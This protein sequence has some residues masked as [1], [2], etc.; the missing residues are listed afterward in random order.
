[1]IAEGGTTP[2]FSQHATGSSIH[3]SSSISRDHSAHDHQ[4]KSRVLLSG[5]ASIASGWKNCQNPTKK[6]FF[7]P[8]GRKL[9]S[10][11]FATA[12]QLQ[13]QN[14]W[15]TKTQEDCC[16]MWLLLRLH[17]LN[18][19][20]VL[21]VRRESIPRYAF[22]FPGIQEWATLFQGILGQPGIMKCMARCQ[23]SQKAQQATRAAHRSLRIDSLQASAG[24]RDD[25]YNSFCVITKDCT[26]EMGIAGQAVRGPSAPPQP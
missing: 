17:Y 26:V 8:V 21:L 14:K 23:Y 5:L 18:S 9:Q 20:T 24:L 4:L 3:A 1:M 11:F 15:P 12:K 16:R 7:P 25:R 19:A 13:M 22:S 2:H 10:S 6:L